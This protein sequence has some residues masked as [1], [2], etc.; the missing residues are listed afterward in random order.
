MKAAWDK[1]VDV[2]EWMADMI[3]D[4]PR[5]ALG[6]ILALVVMALV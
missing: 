5:L 6:V 3:A 1:V 2:Y 4:Y